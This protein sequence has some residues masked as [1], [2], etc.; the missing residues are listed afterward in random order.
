[1][2]KLHTI[3]FSVSLL[4]G[5]AAHA[6]FRVEIAGVSST[7]IPVAV[8]AFADEGV[9]PD[10]VSAI[11][12][13][14]LERSGVFKVI[15]AGQVISDSA[16][17]DAGAWKARGAD[18]LVVGSVSRQPDGRFAVRYK[19]LDTVKG[20]QL[21]ALGGEVQPRYTRLQAHRIADDVYEKLTGVR[22]IFS[23]RI[24]YVK[25]NRAGRNYALA[26]ADSDGENEIIAV[27]GR[28]PII[29][30][31]WSPDGGKVAYVSFEDRKPVIYMQ[32][33]VTGKRRV[34]AN[35]KGSNSA[36]SWSP[37]GSKLAIA[38]SKSGSYQ[39]YIVNADG[40]GL[41][42]LS[43]SNGIDTEPQFSAD[44]QTIYFT[45][46]R[47]GGPQIYK[48]SVNG[49]NATRVTFNGSYNI[50]PR[51][52]PDG[53]TLAWIS[54]RDGGYSLFA[55]DLASGQELRLADGATEPSFSPNGKYIMYANKG[56]GRTALAVVSV[57]GRVKQRLTTKAGNIREPSWGPFM[58]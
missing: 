58:K 50:S 3:L 39:V 44:G 26:V 36:P 9:A 27:Q 4:M 55:M 42:R 7:Q 51:V 31:S 19:L 37:D 15:D 5:S 54:Q 40:S 23:T 53:K 18:A 14:D 12:R 25:E 33:L 46:D 38:L 49:G 22:G 2:K 1:M 17:I 43:T 34:I 21:S 52:A 35:E 28:E 11:I 45:S 32:D 47:S 13:A 29:S 6:Q 10:Q 20:G 24:A 56:G 48:M 57:D 8:A 30:P 41:R 16:N